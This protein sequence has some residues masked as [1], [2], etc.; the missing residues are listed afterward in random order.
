MNLKELS[1]CLFELAKKIQEQEKLAKM[2]FILGMRVVDG[3]WDNT[4]FLDIE[5]Q[6]K[7]YSALL[8]KEGETGLLKMVAPFKVAKKETLKK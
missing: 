2:P 7:Q 1:D 8:L 3:P 5:T 4:K 6:D